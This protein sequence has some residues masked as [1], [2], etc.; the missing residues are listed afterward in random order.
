LS[1]QIRL[2]TESDYERYLKINIPNILNDVVVV[3]NTRFIEEYIQYFYDIC[4]DPNKVNRVILNQVNYADSCDFNNVNVFCV[5]KFTISVDGEYPEFLTNSFKALIKEITKDKK[6]ISNEIVPRD[7]I[8]VAIDLGY[9]DSFDNLSDVNDSNLVVIRSKTIKKSK[10]KIKSDISNIIKNYFKSE[11]VK[12][13]QII[14][15]SNITSD[16]LQIDG[17]QSIRMLNN[18]TQETFNGLSFSMWNPL[19]PDS[20]TQIITQTISLPFFKFPYLINP[21]SLSNKILVIDE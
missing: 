14:N 11:N 19:F 15:V 16:I 8:Y 5:P 2:V 21:V 6:I 20:D 3:D 4:V 12:L 7:P 1:S 9:S 17:V 18:K 10:E 13:G